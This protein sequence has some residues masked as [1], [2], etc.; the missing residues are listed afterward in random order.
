MPST[1][2]SIV[3]NATMPQ[4]WSRLN[5]F[6]DIRLAPNVI[7]QLDKD[8]DIPG[9]EVGAKRVLNDAF[10]ETLI[11]LNENNYKLRYTIDDGP[12]PVSEKQVDNYIG[13]VHLSQV[14]GSEGVKV[15]GIRPGKPMMKVRSNSAI[16][17]TPLYYAD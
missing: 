11:E 12:S 9:T 10:H 5:D 17:S 2:Q 7:K 14:S 4:I 13:T 8:G 3:I 15:T 1:S 6:H 16:A